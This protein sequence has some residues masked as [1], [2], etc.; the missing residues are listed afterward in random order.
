MGPRRK[1]KGDGPG[2]AAL[3]E[4]V[5]VGNGEAAYSAGLVLGRPIGERPSF[6]RPRA[7][8]SFTRSKRLSTL[9]LEPTDFDFLRLG[10]CDMAGCRLDET[11]RDHNRS[12][13]IAKWF[14]AG[15]DPRG[16]KR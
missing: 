12:S 4:S 8:M 2:A 13:A 11:G 9:R 6:Q 16:E 10:C 7:C 15:R 5:R 14:L 1:Q 3:G